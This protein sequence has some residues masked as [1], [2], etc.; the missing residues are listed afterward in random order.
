MRLTDELL[1][2]ARAINWA[3]AHDPGLT[4]TLPVRTESE[5]NRRDKWAAVER[6][7]AQ[8]LAVTLAWPRSR[9]NGWAGRVVVVLTRVSPR[10]RLDGDNLA[11]ALKAIRDGVAATL[12]RDDGESEL[13]WLYQQERGPWAVRVDVFSQLPCR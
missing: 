1:A 6:A 13:T 7:K 11:R 10:G 5:A 3:H 2:Q 9:R 8:R 12:S 4:L